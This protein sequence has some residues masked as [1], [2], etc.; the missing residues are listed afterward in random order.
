ME[1]KNSSGVVM[2]VFRVNSEGQE[3]GSAVF[4]SFSLT[5]DVLLP[6][7]C[8]AP[9]SCKHFFEIPKA[10]I[11]VLNWWYVPACSKSITNRV[12][13]MVHLMNWNTFK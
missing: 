13:T 12:G 4:F 7:S 6:P 9:K 2:N 3:V 1:V 10:W 11:C 8:S 5:S